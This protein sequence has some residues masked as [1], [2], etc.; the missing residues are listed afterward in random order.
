MV[1]NIKDEDAIAFFKLQVITPMLEA[2][3]G[4]VDKTA[5][6][7]SHQQFNDVVNK[8]I[9]TYS[10]RTLYKFYSSYKKFGFDGLKPKIK[11]SKGTHPA[12]PQELI[13]EIM[14][15]KE[16]LPTRSAL[17]IIVMLELAKKIE[18]G[19]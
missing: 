11:S 6:K 10:Y 14:K 2:N 4:F 12:I 1:G 13:D 17:K 5:K 15:L 8:K 18:K 16:E 9:I 19:F 7:L 3:K